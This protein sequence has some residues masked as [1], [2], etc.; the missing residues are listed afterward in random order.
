MLQTASTGHEL[1]RPGSTDTISPALPPTAGPF[2]ALFMQG[3]PDP[4]PAI[5]QLR[6]VSKA[7]EKYPKDIVKA[8]LCL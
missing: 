1:E 5:T 7:E 6:C 4:S 8:G 3:G 2:L